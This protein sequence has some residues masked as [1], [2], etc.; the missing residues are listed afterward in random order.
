MPNQL[1]GETS[2]YLLQH[3]A[4]PVDWY[5]WGEEALS[6]AVREDKPILLSIGYSACHWCHVMERE[7]FENHEIARIMNENFI[8]IKVDREERPDLDTIYMEAVQAICGS[9]GWPLTVFLTPRGRPFYGGTY[10]PAE[11]RSGLPGFPR[12][13]WTVAQ[14]YSTRKGEVE[15]AAE[16]VIAHLN[17]AFEVQRGM[18]PLTTNMLSTAYIALKGAFDPQNGGFGSAPKFPQPMVLEFLLRYYHR[19]GNEDALSMVERSLEGMAKGGIYDQIGGG[20][21]RYS[22]DARWLVPHF[23]KMLYDNALLSRL[24]LHAYQATGKQ[25][26][27]RIVEETLD[28]VLREMSDKGGGFYSTQD[29]DSEG[30]EGKYYAWAL[31]EAIGALGENE[32]R[33]VARYF[34]LTEQG[35]FE[36][37]NIPRQAIEIQALASE[38]GTTTQELGVRIAAAKAHLLERRAHRVSPHR[39]DKILIDWNGLML[40]SLAEAASVLDR[41]D[42][43]EAAVSNATF[44]TRALHDGEILKHSYKDG[45][46]GINGYLLDYAL[47]CE[48]LLSL[49]E[50]TF[51]QQWL[52]AAID[53][54]NT[55][56]D[57]FWVESHG[58][59]Y[60]SRHSQKELVVRPRN[61]YDNALPSGSAATAFVLLHLARLTDNSYYETL[62]AATIRSVRELIVRHPLSFGHW[63]AALDFYLSQPK[64]IVVVGQPIDPATKSLM[65]VITRRYLPNKV[66]TGRNPDESAQ[67]IDIPLLQNRLLVGNTPTVY[68]CE[69]CVCQTPVTDPD[70]LD[71]QLADW[72]G[73][74]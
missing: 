48:G 56:I 39:D 38:F 35:N 18:E 22:V 11:D 14:A 5:P 69:N 74:A 26:Y 19:T 2:P 7:C 10:F 9:G 8:N 53:L 15:A 27:R 46:A 66:L 33:L 21:H 63:L 67:T 6:R 60:D 31:D 58:C 36:G 50:A 72:Q 65:G 71:R 16:Q 68:L 41:E 47:L 42:Y 59:L 40:A 64:E 3:A 23:E 57:Q 54:A 44:L 4:N 30:I 32:G 12:V 62:A 20:F 29:A 45:Q 13:L 28:Y 1:I 52:Q 17:R 34:G 24:Y 49:Y 43:L 61:V 25:L 55:L 37:A 70:A 51:Q 73:E